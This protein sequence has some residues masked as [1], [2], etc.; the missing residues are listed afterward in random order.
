MV[1]LALSPPS[2][3]SCLCPGTGSPS[4]QNPTPWPASSPSPAPPWLSTSGA[5]PARAR[6][7]RRC[8]LHGV[9]DMLWNLGQAA[10][11]SPAPKLGSIW[12]RSH[13]LPALDYILV[14]CC[15]FF[16]LYINVACFF[17]ASLCVCD[18]SVFLLVA[19]SCLLSSLYSISSFAAVY[20]L[21][22][23]S[24]YAPVW[25]CY[26]QCS[27][28]SCMFTCGVLADPAPLVE[29]LNCKVCISSLTR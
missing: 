3:R 19:A 9:G 1:T 6:G 12:P 5:S 11:P 8:S 4:S 13:G 14:Q 2:T 10:S 28:H 18:L 21:I 20:L 15:L 23:L 7:H 25:D 29:L 26:R 22:L 17:H 24:G 16:K 27:K